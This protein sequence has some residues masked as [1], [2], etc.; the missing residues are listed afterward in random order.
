[1]HGL[2]HV[3]RRRERC[4]Q[5]RNANPAHCLVVC[6]TLHSPM[7]L[8]PCT[9]TPAFPSAVVADQHSCQCMHVR[10]IMPR[11]CQKP[12][13]CSILLPRK[14]ICTP[15]GMR[16]SAQVVISDNGA[17]RKINGN[18]GTGGTDDG[19][20]TMSNFPLRGGKGS[21]FEGGMRTTGILH[22]TAR[23]GPGGYP[24]RW[25]GLPAEAVGR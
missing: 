24:K 3:G 18:A 22:I 5:R 2:W 20:A 1:M 10:L 8:F 6:R 16:A 4:L 17:A 25:A 14:Y 7:F 21:P 11:I 23:A 19:I 9:P 15:S 13:T 12:P